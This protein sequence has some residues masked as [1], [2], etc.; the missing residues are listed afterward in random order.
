MDLV[1]FVESPGGG[2]NAAKEVGEGKG[3]KSEAPSAP[4]CYQRAILTAQDKDSNFFPMMNTEKLNRRN[5][6]SPTE[7]QDAREPI[8]K[9]PPTHPQNYTQTPPAFPIR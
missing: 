4:D 5:L 2:F 7:K 3:Q 9:S 6:N 8:L 1:V